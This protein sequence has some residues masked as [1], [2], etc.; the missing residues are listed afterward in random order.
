MNKRKKQ[1]NKGTSESNQNKFSASQYANQI[2]HLLDLH[3]GRAYTLKQ[4]QQH[5]YARNKRDKNNV[6]A[7]LHQLVQQGKIE[8]FR[9]HFQS[10]SASVNM[11]G[12]VDH[13]SP[14]FAFVIPQEGDENDVMIRTPDL[15]GAIDGDIV[16][17]SI[18]PGAKGRDGRKAGEVKEIIER[19]HTEIVGSLELSEMYG[20][21][22]PN[23]RKIYEDI[24]IPGNK[25]GDAK[26][27]DL[28]IAE[29]TRWPEK[30]NKNPEG[31]IKK[32]LGKVGENDAE[33]HAIMLEFGLPYEF[34]K[35]ILTI[36]EQIPEN[37]PEY[38][39]KKRRDFRPVTTFTI[40]P[41]DAKDFDDA[42]SIRTLDNGNF[43]IGVHIADVTYYLKE[44]SI[45]DK[46][47]YKRATSVYLVDRTVPM[48]PEKL[49]NNL[50]SL[51][52]NVDR[53]C[54]SAVFEMDKNAK[55]YNKW[56]GRA[57]IHSDRR[58]SYKEAQ[59]LIEGKKGDYSED[60]N[61][62]NDLALKL[63]KK[64]FDEG[65]ISFESTEIKFDLDEN[66]KPIG[67]IPKVRKEAHKMIEDFMLLANK[68]VAE[69]IYNFKGTKG[70]YTFVY[71]THDYPDHE[72]LMNFAAFAKNFGHNINIEEQGLSK[73]L[74]KLSQEVEG[75][76]EQ[77]ILQSLAIRAMAKAVYTTAPNGHFGLGFQHY[78]HFTSPIRRYPDALVHRLLDNYLNNGKNPNRAELE[79]K[80]EHSSSMEKLASDAERASTKYKQIEWMQEMV[81]EEFDGIISGMNDFGIYVELVETKCEGM[82][83]MR[84]IESDYF[85]LQPEKF[86]I[87]G[88]KS[89]KII[90][91]GDKIRVKVKSTDINRRTMDL[92]IADDGN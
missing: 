8:Q 20:F 79:K 31:R 24:F 7:T 13:V 63:R 91:F 81:G 43:E 82:I 40:D 50:C 88:Q 35:E 12:R 54:Y 58:F 51:K 28:V 65:S 69:Y 60:I 17:I 42:L 83:R 3:P 14:H 18:F 27:N 15:N 64:R 80:C 45:L 71:R 62:L 67:L 61:T 85:E 78:T 16:K 52:P 37:I 19:K 49:S 33:M 25:L 76:P 90:K 57:I 53:L 21:V 92:V 10:K 32:I 48:L 72:K 70:Q 22:I 6:E 38:E 68:S 87:V 5:L 41:A 34:S 29:I 66:G 55:V 23:S 30:A 75:K 39:I 77:N 2:M 11:T 84:D 4:V 44:G 47:A 73:T 74:N 46:E 86:R 56:F 36:A 1:S 26:E 59:E 9:K 89:G